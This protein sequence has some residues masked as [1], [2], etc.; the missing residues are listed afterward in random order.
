MINISELK[1]IVQEICLAHPLVLL[2][3]F[4]QLEVDENGVVTINVSLT[5]ENIALK[6]TISKQLSSRL[7]RRLKDSGIRY[8]YFHKNFC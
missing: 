3:Y 6:P 5:I 8:L 4:H 7:K 2:V 1:H